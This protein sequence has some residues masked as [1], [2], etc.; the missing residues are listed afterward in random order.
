MTRRL[1][2]NL[3]LRYELYTQPVDARDV[4]GQFNIDTQQYVLP[5]KNGY[6]RAMAKGDHNNLGPRV[7]F[8]YQWTPKFVMRSA[9]GIFYGLRDQN[10]QTTNSYGN[11]PN[12]PT[13]VNPTITASG[14]V[15]PPITLNTPITFSPT[16]P[17]LKEFSAD[18]PAAITIQTEAFN[19]VPAP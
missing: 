14:T 12:V 3:G 7:G 17:T 11:I 8:A 4:G 2:L 10:D 19:N 9:Y 5:G 1:T 6:S 15:T 18:R 13:L 16:D